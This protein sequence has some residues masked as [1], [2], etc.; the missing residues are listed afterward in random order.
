MSTQLH[1]LSPRYDVT[2]LETK[3][4]SSGEDNRRPLGLHTHEY[5]TLAVGF[6]FVR[7]FASKC[8]GR[9][10]VSFRLAMNFTCD[11]MDTMVR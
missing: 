5:N 8:L 10:R 4:R 11:T 7:L 9:F 3:T 1:Q 6:A 2:S